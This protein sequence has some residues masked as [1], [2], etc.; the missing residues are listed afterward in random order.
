MF[1]KIRD[2]FF[3]KRPSFAP[4]VE[5]NLETIHSSIFGI[6]LNLSTYS[7]KSAGSITFP[8]MSLIRANNSNIGTFAATEIE[9][10]F[11]LTAKIQS[12]SRAVKILVI[13]G[14]FCVYFTNLEFDCEYK[15]IVLGPNSFAML[16]AVSAY[17]NSIEILL[18]ASEK[19]TIPILTTIV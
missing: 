2:I 1:T 18:F 12:L 9:S 8:S 6:I 10:I 4:Y 19:S 16:Q 17:D 15:C 7:K 11:C 14:T 13:I 5:I 3:N